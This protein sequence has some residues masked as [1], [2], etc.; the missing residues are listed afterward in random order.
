MTTN[1][2][3]RDLKLLI[4]EDHPIVRQGLMRAL[5][6]S[7]FRA[8]WSICLYREYEESWLC[9]DKKQY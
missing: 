4:I 6:A 7:G 2:P 1:E 3:E 5:E 8:G 9:Y